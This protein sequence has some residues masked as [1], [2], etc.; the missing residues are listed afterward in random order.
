VSTEGDDDL[1]W[2]MMM[3]LLVLAEFQLRQGRT[4]TRSALAAKRA[5]GERTGALPYGY[6]LGPEGVLVEDLEQ[7]RALGLMQR[8]QTE[9]ASLSAIAARLEAE[10][11]KPKRGR[12]W[13]AQ[14]V[15]TILA[16]AKRRSG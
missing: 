15:K 10:G 5:R 16:T 7:L 6:E 2:L 11:V 12:R 14:S 4:R 9:G 1:S 13:Y 3:I 8:M